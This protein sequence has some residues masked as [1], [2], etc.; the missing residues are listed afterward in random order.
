MTHDRNG[1]T[2]TTDSG[3]LAMTDSMT[4][5]TAGH[6][7]ANLALEAARVTEAAAIG[8]YAHMGRGDEEAADRAAVA[9]VSRALNRLPVATQITIGEGP[10]GEAADLYTGQRT[11]DGTGPTVDVAVM[12]LEGT[13]IVARGGFNAISAIAFAEGHRFLSA[14]AVYMDKI[15]VGSGLTADV[16]SLDA[17]PK[18]NISSVAAARGL[19]PDDL[20]VCILD[21]PRHRD[22]IE[23]VRAT[24]AGIRLIMDGDLSGAVSPVRGDSGIDIYMGT[25]LAPQGILAAAALRCAGGQIQGRLVART[26]KDREQLFRAGIDDPDTVYT[27]EAMAPG[28]I[29]FA[30]TGITSGLLL[31][32]VG[33]TPYRRDGYTYVTR[34]MVL[35]SHSGSW[36]EMETHH[37]RDGA[38]PKTP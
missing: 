15:S 34:S 6:M 16:V 25:G 31:P 20:V 21:R 28:D 7:T 32:G 27:T 38:V 4:D 2:G 18:D 17:A 14:P 10:E 5:S 19:K 29:T 13:S 1:T 9:A 30:A 35:R 23:N 12:A 33:R 36:R 3:I 22:L 37:H 11:R 26:A 24:G 8:A